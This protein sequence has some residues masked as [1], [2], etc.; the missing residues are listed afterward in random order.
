VTF[1]NLKLYYYTLKDLKISQ[2]LFH[3]KFIFIKPKFLDTKWTEKKIFYVRKQKLNFLE[4]VNDYKKINF[5]QKF[6][7]LEKFENL[8]SKLKKF[9]L[10]YLNHI[11]NKKIP[12]NKKKENIKK[13]YEYSLINKVSIAWHP[14][15]TSIRLMNLIKFRYSNNLNS[16]FIDN[17]IYSHFSNLTRSLE[18]NLNANHLLT[19]IIAINT[20]L[21]TCSLKTKEIKDNKKKYFNKLDEVLKDQFKSSFHYENSPKYHLFL[22]K[23]ILDLEILKKIV[24]KKNNYKN[25]L[26]I[27]K[28]LNFILDIIHPDGTLPFFNDTN[29]NHIKVDKIKKKIEDNFGKLRNFKFKKDI[30]PTIN[31]KQ[32]KLITKCCEPS[33]KY[34]PGHTHGDN[35]SF[36]LS[37]LNIRIMTGR[38][39]STYENN[40]DR[41]TQRSSKNHNAIEINGLSANEVWNSFRVARK[42]KISNLKI[43]KNS[44]YAECLGYY[45]NSRFN[46]HK[47]KWI[48]KNRSLQI[49]DNVKNKYFKIYFNFTPKTN[50]KYNKI[51]DCYLIKNGNV[52][53]KISFSS[54]KHTLKE[55]NYYENF[56]NIKKSFCIE[57]F[58]KENCNTTIKLH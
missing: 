16:K 47:R 38:G 56:E 49:L 35:L 33:P 12:L 20:F 45:H 6:N 11:L 17:F 28:G 7:L 15:P 25:I 37:I 41:K 48:L 32:F 9:N 24:E 30:F 2:F 5:Y 27:K 26:L 53:A 42:S 13:L 18:Y 44:I 34:N 54:T 1:K 3:L 51:D 46:V 14:Y 21:V 22:I 19:N 10:F 31:N 8:N 39:I 55:L 4:D 58:S 36:E 43:S 29:K 40:N 23:Q 50:V 57:I 52:N